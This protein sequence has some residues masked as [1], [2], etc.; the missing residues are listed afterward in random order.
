M[1]D[2]REFI[3]KTA[4]T[5]MGLSL[6]GSS[7]LNGSPG[8]SQPPSL[9]EIKFPV[10]TFTKPLQF[11]GYEDLADILAESGM[12]GADL[13]V[14]MGAHV[15]P[16]RVEDELPRAVEVLGSRGIQ[17]P[18]MVT[19][20]ND[21]ADPT[22]EPVLKTASEQGIGI[23][24]MA[25]YK[26]DLQLGI[27]K[28]LEINKSKLKGL[29]EINEKHKIH[30]AYQNHNGRYVGSPVWDLWI[31]LKDLD[32][33]WTGCQYDIRHAVAEGANSWTLG[34]ELLKKHIKCVVVKDFKWEKINGKWKM[35]NVPLGEGMV[36]FDEFLGY[37]KNFS[38]EG[39]VDIHCEYPFFDS[40]DKSLTLE[41]KRKAALS[42]MK[43]DV[44][45]I[46]QKMME[47]GLN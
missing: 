41:Q 42:Y 25:Y 17:V 45:F 12:D 11:L 28:N 9:N 13:G 38:F 26:Y 10:C 1:K 23:Y 8:L 3:K 34:I 35:V 24:R 30:G 4:L 27:E 14:R 47:F 37:L 21:P 40:K 19:R 5:G 32:P 7:L 2:R 43:K 31:L 22:A 6:A 33:Q 29:A 36:D 46:R 20:I 16:E 15:E 39:P 18:M 44:E